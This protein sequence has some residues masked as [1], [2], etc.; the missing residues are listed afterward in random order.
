MIYLVGSKEGRSG[1]FVAA[2]AD[3]TFP[4]TEKQDLAEE[5]KL[6]VVPRELGI[7]FKNVC[8][9]ENCFAVFTDQEACIDHNTSA[10]LLPVAVARWN[11]RWRVR[12]AFQEHAL[13]ATPLITQ[14]R[15]RG[16]G[17]LLSS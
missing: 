10:L 2:D 14:A 4:S 7:R 8:V 17:H 5:E 9:Q 1:S 3:R 11:M 13:S 16:P 6:F 15:S 12:D